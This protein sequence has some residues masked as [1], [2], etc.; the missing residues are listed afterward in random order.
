VLRGPF[1]QRLID[2]GVD[3]SVGSV[4]D[5]YDNALA[6]TT[7]ELEWVVWFNH[8]LAFCLRQTLPGRVRARVSRN[9][10]DSITKAANEQ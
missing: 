9:S 2:A 8:A 5:A 6:E 1:T 4:G 10:S 3:T 7:I